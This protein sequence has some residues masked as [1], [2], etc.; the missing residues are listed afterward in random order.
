MNT[1]IPQI[2][3]KGN[4]IPIT[5][6]ILVRPI[7]TDERLALEQ[8][9]CFLQPFPSERPDLLSG[10]MVT[11]PPLMEMEQVTSTDSIL[12]FPDGLKAALAHE[13]GWYHLSLESRYLDLRPRL[14][15]IQRRTCFSSAEVARLAE[16]DEREVILCM[17]RMAPVSETDAIKVLAAVSV[18]VNRD[19]SLQTVRVLIR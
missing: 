17:F 7:L 8:H 2:P 19:Y 11:F 3:T 15:D 1:G 13:D 12:H 4:I 14:I 10:Y 5:K 18:I 6:P 9:G 16:V